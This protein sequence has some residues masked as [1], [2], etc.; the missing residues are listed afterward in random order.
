MSDGHMF[1]ANV[2]DC[3]LK[4]CCVCMDLTRSRMEAKTSN[5]VSI[6]TR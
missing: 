4:S 3:W 5:I 1:L 6:A 2:G